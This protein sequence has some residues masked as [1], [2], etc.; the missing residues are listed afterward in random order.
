MLTLSP[1]MLNWIDADMPSITEEMQAT[2]P[3][4]EEVREF[5]GLFI[6][7]LALIFL[8]FSTPKEARIG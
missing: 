6:T 4:I 2:E 1:G 7:V 3:H 8:T 5:L